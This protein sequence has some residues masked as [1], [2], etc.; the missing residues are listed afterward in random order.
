MNTLYYIFLLFILLYLIFVFKRSNYEIK[1]QSVEYIIDIDFSLATAQDELIESVQFN[2]YDSSNIL[3]HTERKIGDQYPLG[4]VN[5]AFIRDS[6]EQFKFLLD[7]SANVNVI[8]INFSRYQDLYTYVKYKKNINTNQVLA[9]QQ[10]NNNYGIIINKRD[11]IYTQD[12]EFNIDYPVEY[13]SI[14]KSTLFEFFDISGN[15]TYS[16][17]RDVNNKNMK[18]TIKLTEPVKRVKI[19][20]KDFRDDKIFIET[21]EIDEMLI[22]KNI[23]E[24]YDKSVDCSLTNVYTGNV[25]LRQND[26]RPI[27]EMKKVYTNL[28]QV[29]DTCYDKTKTNLNEISYTQDYP[30]NDLEGIN[31]DCGIS[32]SEPECPPTRDGGTVL[33]KD[34]E[35]KWESMGEGKSCIQS[36]QEN[37]GSTY[38]CPNCNYDWKYS[39]KRRARTDFPLFKEYE[40]EAVYNDSQYKQECENVFGILENKWTNTVPTSNDNIDFDCEGYYSEWTACEIGPDSNG[41]MVDSS[42]DWTTTGP[43]INNGIPCPNLRTERKQCPNCTHDYKYTGEYTIN[44]RWNR[45]FIDT[46]YKKELVFGNPENKEICLELHP[47][48]AQE[49]QTNVPP[50]D[51]DGVD[52]DCVGVW[53]PLEAPICPIDGTD[54]VQRWITHVQS[55]GNGNSC[56]SENIVTECVDCTSKWVYTG[57]FKTNVYDVGTYFDLTPGNETCVVISPAS[58]T[59]G[60]RTYTY[61]NDNVFAYYAH[62]IVN[63]IWNPPGLNWSHPQYSDDVIEARVNTNKQIC[64][65][66]SSEFGIGVQ[67]IRL[68]INEYYNYGATFEQ[69]NEYNINSNTELCTRYPLSEYPQWVSE[70]SGHDSGINIDCQ[71]EWLTP[72]CTREGGE[73]DST[74]EVHIPQIGSGEA[75]PFTTSTTQ[76]PDCTFKWKYTGNYRIVEKEIYDENNYVKLWNQSGGYPIYVIDGIVNP[77]RLDKDGNPWYREHDSSSTILKI[78]GGYQYFKIYVNTSEFEQKAEYNTYSGDC[79][80]FPLPTPDIRWVHDKPNENNTDVKFDCYN[81]YDV[82][83]TENCTQQGGATP[84]TILRKMVPA[85]N[86]GI[87]CGYGG[88]CPDCTHKWVYTGMYKSTFYDDNNYIEVEM[89]YPSWR[90]GQPP[91]NNRFI[92]YHPDYNDSWKIPAIVVRNIKINGTITSNNDYDIIYELGSEKYSY[93]WF[94]TNTKFTKRFEIKYKNP[95]YEEIK[96]YTYPENESLCTK[97][98]I[99]TPKNRWVYD[100]TISQSHGKTILENYYDDNSSTIGHIDKNIFIERGNILHL[101]VSYGYD[102]IKT[103][104]ND[105]IGY[106]ETANCTLNGKRQYNWITTNVPSGNGKTCNEVSNYIS[107][108]KRVQDPNC[109]DCTRDARYTGN[110]I[111]GKQEVQWFYVNNVNQCKSL[112]EIDDNYKL[113]HNG[114]PYIP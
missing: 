40:L 91:T 59:G 80:D 92:I 83:D 55:A 76:C 22:I 103:N 84:P 16:I 41:E 108:T 89:E 28:R 88:S 45:Y 57:E 105:C 112:A 52:I 31:I 19:Y 102:T 25:E 111:D 32:I 24:F 47:T 65:D 48:I 63:G 27:F 74:F 29:D 78:E 26:G 81:I 37:G 6:R 93:D 97:Y 49:I 106:W 53:D 4:G 77:P 54:Q 30:D 7:K 75:C 43:A 95:V 39:G 82:F 73:L 50:T 71:G 87:N 36:I 64:Y 62:S 35:I 66:C 60:R 33:Q 90:M 3:I 109:I 2:F 98:P 17:E 86:G 79:S 10:I 13:K 61:R 100:N 44:K 56:P 12:F 5:P 99:G 18:Y 51:S 38:M 67:I 107:T 69:N 42:R 11:I 94:G 101:L 96:V 110:V 68:Q 114:E 23:P 15:L 46:T 8:Q 21:R 70:V 58:L 72:M 9:G 1:V 85:I 14:V 113:P 34:I 104:Q 20:Y